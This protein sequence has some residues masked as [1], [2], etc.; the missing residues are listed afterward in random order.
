MRDRSWSRANVERTR[1]RE[2]GREIDGLEHR[3]Y[4]RTISARRENSVG[5]VEPHAV[6]S[7]RLG[8]PLVIGKNVRAL[9][10]AHRRSTT[11]NWKDSLFGRRNEN[12]YFAVFSVT[13]AD[14]PARAR[15]FDFFSSPAAPIALFVTRVRTG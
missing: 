13:D 12:R 8:G 11:R 6:G 5:V 9:A 1:E 3:R 14:G 4:F 2:R 7:V 15:D 10:R